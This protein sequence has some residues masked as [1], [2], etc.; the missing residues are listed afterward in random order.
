MKT[1]KTDYKYQNKYFVKD[2]DTQTAV[3]DRSVGQNNK[4]FNG[5]VV[6]SKVHTVK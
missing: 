2:Y 1:R 6:G 5:V 3:Y 4:T